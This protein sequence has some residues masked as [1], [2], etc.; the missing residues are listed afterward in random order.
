MS[1]LAENPPSLWSRRQLLTTVA[2]R[3][4]ATSPRHRACRQRAPGLRPSVNT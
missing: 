4:G 3:G 2:A 1:T